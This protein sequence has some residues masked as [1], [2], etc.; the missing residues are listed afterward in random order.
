[1]AVPNY[2]DVSFPLPYN[3][4]NSEACLYLRKALAHG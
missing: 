2:V 3:G 4:K 1:M